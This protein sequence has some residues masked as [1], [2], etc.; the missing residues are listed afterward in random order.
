M[1]HID[2]DNS[3][4]TS[5]SF[6]P[7][8]TFDITFSAIIQPEVSSNRYVIITGWKNAYLYLINYPRRDDD[9]K[10]VNSNLFLGSNITYDLDITTNEPKISFDSSFKGIPLK[11]RN[12][13]VDVITYTK[14]NIIYAQIKT[15]EKLPNEKTNILFFPFMKIT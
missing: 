12:S 3:I 9:L 2:N 14:N 1:E 8:N 13:E 5:L 7:L 15:P 4:Y 6:K 11:N 10:C